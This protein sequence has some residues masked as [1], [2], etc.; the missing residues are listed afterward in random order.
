MLVVEEDHIQMEKVRIEKTR[1]AGKVIKVKNIEDVE[2]LK[3][4][5][6][7]ENLKVDTEKILNAVLPQKV[8]DA[9]LECLMN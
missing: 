9:V 6:N 1:E 8:S 7:V 5:K 3:N 2:G 4:L